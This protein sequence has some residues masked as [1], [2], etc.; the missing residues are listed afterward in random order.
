M[1]PKPK[2]PATIQV[3]RAGKTNEYQLAD[4]KDWAVIFDDVLEIKATDG[5]CYY[6]PLP[7]LTLWKVK[8][9]VAP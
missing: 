9:H 2:T 7:S 5:C 1:A 3:I 6:W 4:S 8:E